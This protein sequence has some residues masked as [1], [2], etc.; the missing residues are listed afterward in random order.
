MG[1][2]SCKAVRAQMGEAQKIASGSGS[3]QDI[4]E[5]KAELEVR[6]PRCTPRNHTPDQADSVRC[7]TH[8]KRR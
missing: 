6:T 2:P 4:A 3:E 1:C 5:A 7:W 8:Y